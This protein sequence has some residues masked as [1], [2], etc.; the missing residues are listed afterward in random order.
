LKRLVLLLRKPPRIP[1]QKKNPNPHLNP[2][3]H[4]NPN[5][6]LPLL[7]LLVVLPVL[8][9]L[10]VGGEPLEGQDEERT[11]VVVVVLLLVDEVVGVVEGVGLGVGRRRQV[12]VVLAVR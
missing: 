3:P 9:H 10:E 5:P 6:L 4:P 2:N 12:V 11:L 7:P 8:P 1:P